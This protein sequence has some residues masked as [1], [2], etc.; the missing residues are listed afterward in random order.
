MKIFS[1]LSLVLVSNLARAEDVIR[2]EIG[3]NYDGYSNADLKRRVWLLEQAVFQLQQRVFSLEVS[4]PAKD[5]KQ[6]TC[7]ISSF[8]KSYHESEATKALARAKVIQACAKASSAM[9]CSDDD[10]ECSNE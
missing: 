10:V 5:K 6:W 3:K 9:H 7:Q 1:L 2:I 4:K 8:G